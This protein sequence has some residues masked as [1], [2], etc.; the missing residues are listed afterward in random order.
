MSSKNKDIDQELVEL[1]PTDDEI[2]VISQ[3]NLPKISQPS[4][5]EVIKEKA[6]TGDPNFDS[7]FIKARK[8]IHDTLDIASSAIEEM[9]NI[10]EQSGHPKAYE[11]LNQYI[12]SLSKISKDLVELYK[13]RK[14]SESDEDKDKKDKEKNTTN[15]LVFVGS[16]SE[17][18]QIVKDATNK[19]K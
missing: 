13:I 7:D 6:A 9:R 15:N 3:K 2:E 5:I 19:K 8:T 12:K 4:E 14:D 18:A 16:T 17:L 10:A 1:F 11:V